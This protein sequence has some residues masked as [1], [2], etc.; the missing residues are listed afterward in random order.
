[1]RM[2]SLRHGRQ[3]AAEI[4]GPVEQMLAV[5]LPGFERVGRPRRELPFARTAPGFFEY[6]VAERGLRPESIVSY[7]HHHQLHL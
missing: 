7:R 6:L 1:M 3:S 4:R 2:A 5:V